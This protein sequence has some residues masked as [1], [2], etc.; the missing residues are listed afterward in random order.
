MPETIDQIMEDASQALVE[1]FYARCEILCLEALQQARGESD[2]GMVRRILLPLQEARRQKRQA[3]IDGPVLLGTPDPTK[4][5]EWLLEQECGCVV[6]TKPFNQTLANSMWMFIHHAGLPVEILLADNASSDSSWRITSFS[7]PAIYTD[8]PAPD[9]SWIG[10]ALSSADMNPPT[11]AHWFMRASEAIGNAAIDAVTDEP[12]TVE[13]F[14]A[15]AAALSAVG[16]HE[17]LHQALAD[18]AKALHEAQR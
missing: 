13:R 16:D 10:K 5:P 11:P 6:I 8:L 1:M 3:A 17:L 2:W 4:S 12:G 7:N 14:D 15:L 18:A 9:P